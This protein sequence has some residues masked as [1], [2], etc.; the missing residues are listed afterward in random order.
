MEKLIGWLGGQRLHAHL[1]RARGQRKYACA[2]ASSILYAAGLSERAARR[3]F[4]ASDRFDPLVRCRD[5]AHDAA[6]SGSTSVPVSELVLSADSQ[7]PASARP[8]SGCSA[9]PSATNSYPCRYRRGAA[10]PF[11]ASHCA[12]ALCRRARHAVR[13][14]ARGGRDPRPSRR[15]GARPSGSTRSSTAA[16]PSQ[17]A[18]GPGPGRRALQADPADAALSRPR[19]SGGG[20]RRWRHSCMHRFSRSRRRRRHPWSSISG[21]GRTRRLHRRAPGRRRQRVRRHRLCRRLAARRKRVIYRHR[22][23]GRTTALA[24]G[25]G[26]PA[27]SASR[28]S[29]TGGRWRG[30]CRRALWRSA[31]STR[32]STARHDR[33]RAGYSRRPGAAAPQALEEGVELPLRDHGALEGDLCVASSSRRRSPAR[34]SPPPARRA[35]TSHMPAATAPA[36]REYRLLSRYGSRGAEATL[37]GGGVA[38]RS[39]PSRAHPRHGGAALQRSPR[40]RA[41]R[42]GTVM[43]LDIS[44]TSSP[45]VSPMTR[46]R[47]S[48]A[49]RSSGGQ[50]PQADT[51]GP[52]RLQRVNWKRKWRCAPPSSPS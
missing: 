2:A 11:P 48:S 26:G 29:I 42:H 21:G 30:R 46:P 27:W 17:G 43:R 3:L 25:A 7:S 52:P 34:R 33:R 35:T 14:R 13:L 44:M 19:R 36:G 31:C 8:M 20:T 5:A 9:P 4:R 50:R 18:H 28:S 49:P 10:T 1:D 24:A 38:W 40:R 22:G 39:W 37:D 16:R 45:P 15:G 6:R 47:T 32:P 12:A 23:A 51:D 41:M